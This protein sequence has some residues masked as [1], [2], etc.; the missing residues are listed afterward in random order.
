MS[1]FTLE[2]LNLTLTIILIICSTHLSH[3]CTLTKITCN[4]NQN[5]GADLRLG[6]CTEIYLDYNS[7]KIL[8]NLKMTAICD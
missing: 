6:A 3:E 4:P 5:L 7:T 8:T 1:A 2:A